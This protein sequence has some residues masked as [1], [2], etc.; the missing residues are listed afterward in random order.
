[1][2]ACHENENFNG[3]FAYM[4]MVISNKLKYLPLPLLSKSKSTIATAEKQTHYRI[5]EFKCQSL[6]R[7][8]LLLLFGVIEMVKETK[9]TLRNFWG[10]Q[11]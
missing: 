3:S 6:H 4:T 7:F 11:W 10:M 2:A 9:T 5:L 8:G 1:M